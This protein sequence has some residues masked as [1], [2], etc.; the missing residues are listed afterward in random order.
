MNR[1]KKNKY[2]LKY[3]LPFILFIIIKFKHPTKKS[4]SLLHI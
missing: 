4:I 2:Y 3:I 1:G